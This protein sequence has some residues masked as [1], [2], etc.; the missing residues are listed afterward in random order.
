MTYK[1]ITIRKGREGDMEMSDLPK[2][3]FKQQF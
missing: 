2:M 3:I 1:E